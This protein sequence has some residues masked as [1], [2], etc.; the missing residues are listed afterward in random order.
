MD[1][2]AA[3]VL[4]GG[5]AERFQESEKRWFDKAL[6]RLSKKPLLIHV[7]E[8][9]QRV[10]DEIVICVNDERRRQRYREVLTRY[11]MAN[12]KLAIDVRI[13]NL[14]GPLVA[15]LTGLRN[16]QAK[17]CFTIPADMPL[18]QPEIID[19]LFRSANGAQVVVPTWPSGRL[20]TLVMV[21]DKPEALEIAE[22]L[23]MLGR[24]RSDDVIR[25]ASTARFVSIVDEIIKFDPEFR[26]FVNINSREDLV[27]LRP[28][29]A[30]APFTGN[31]SLDCGTL[32]IPRFKDL[33]EASELCRKNKFSE[34]AEIFSDAAKYLEKNSSFFWGAVSWENQGKSLLRLLEQSKEMENNKDKLQIARESLLRAANNYQLESVFH[35]KCGHW[36]LAERAKSD[37]LWCES[38]AKQFG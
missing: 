15:I 31:K 4:A 2:R 13:D 20:E 34:A 27:K 21:L 30:Q 26:S 28:R 12:V 7:V 16:V 32:Q 38:R 25:G 1:S 8:N 10:V 23:C 6:V 3:I 22:T 35:E 9:V 11:G 18:M 37:K 33:R 14:G 5:K 29:S 17:A 24:P 19:Y 36:F